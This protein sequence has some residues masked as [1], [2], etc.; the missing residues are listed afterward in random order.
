[1]TDFE[2]RKLQL[3]QK[4]ILDEVVR[5]CD[6]NNIKYYLSFGTLL[7][8]VRHKGFIPWDDDLDISMPREDYDKFCKIAKENLSEKYSFIDYNI[9]KYYGLCFAKVIKNNTTLLENNA[10]PK[11][12]NGIYIDIFPIDKVG[13]NV[14]L[15]SED[16]FKYKRLLLAKCKYNVAT[17]V[18]S[19]FIYKI[20]WLQSLFYSK[21]KIIN[22]IEKLIKNISEGQCNYCYEITGS[23]VK[24]KIKKYNC[25][26]NFV[27]SI[28][29]EFEGDL[30]KAPKNYNEILKVEYGDYMK[31]PPIEERENRH[32]IIKLSFGEEK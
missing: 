4:E 13:K 19:N 31:L 21:K 1:M 18:K 17:N 6:N 25:L 10:N 8:A 15:Y 32:N 29:I 30:Y 5:I 3:V 16:L 11:V 26:S 2:L 27:E 14:N 12:K 28:D 24:K 9:E 22:N 23:A 20:L 7:G